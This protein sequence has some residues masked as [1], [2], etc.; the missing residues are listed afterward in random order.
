MSSRASR[1]RPSWRV[2]V[3]KGV[4][5]GWAALRRVGQVLFNIQILRVAQ[6]QGAWDRLSWG[7]VHALER[8]LGSNSFICGIRVE[9][10]IEILG[11]GIS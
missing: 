10:T 5:S 2:K 11:K 9:A 3:G 6:L 1:T 8:D 7:D 4:A